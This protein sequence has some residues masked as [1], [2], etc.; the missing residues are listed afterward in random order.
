MVIAGNH[1]KSLPVGESGRRV[2]V[3]RPY[4]YSSDGGRFEYEEHNYVVTGA[5]GGGQLEITVSRAEESA[6]ETLYMA[7]AHTTVAQIQA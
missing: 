6:E 4:T 2:E 3:N 7:R 5:L 1:T